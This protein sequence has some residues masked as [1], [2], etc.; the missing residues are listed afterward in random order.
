[1]DDII[2]SG[3][4][5]ILIAGDLFHTSV[6]SIDHLRLAVKKFKQAQEAGIAIYTIAGSHD[7]SPSGKTM[8][9]VL[10]EAGLVMNVLKG[11]VDHDG[12]LK[13]CFITDK[14]TGAKITGIAGL[15]GMLDR[16][17]YRRLDMASLEREPGYKIFLFHTAV[18]ELMPPDLALPDAQPASMLPKG[19]DYY[20]GGHVHIV[21]HG[22]TPTHKN[23]V[24][25]GPLFP[26]NFAELE[27]LR[28]GGYMLVTDKVAE[29]IPLALQPVTTFRI[30][31]RQRSPDIVQQDLFSRAEGHLYKGHI[32]LTRIEG[33]L[34]H[35]KPEDIPTAHLINFFTQRGASVVMV[36]K[37]RLTTA[38]FSGTPSAE[39]T[40]EEIEEELIKE[41]TGTM[42]VGFH[43]E[44]RIIKQLMQVMSL[45]RSDGEKAADYLAKIKRNTEDTL[46]L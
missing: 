36:N 17:H 5:F 28:H 8:I 35:G 26:V 24:Y 14:K 11:T 33:E 46:L 45:E 34:S 10:E 25:P 6:P 41:R 19:F 32:I 27:Q 3:V 16:Q 22:S 30:D 13:L 20:A 7:F 29:F 2:A 43:D 15:A 9:D 38:E 23:L 40:P 42:P 39:H 1:M 18:K 4:D 31:A 37:S 21:K 44:A 12:V